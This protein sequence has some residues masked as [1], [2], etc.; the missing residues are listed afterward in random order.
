MPKEGKKA[1]FDDNGETAEDT[2]CRRRRQ[3][4]AFDGDEAVETETGVAADETAAARIKEKK[5]QAKAKR[6]EENDE[7]LVEALPSEDVKKKKKKRASEEAEAEE[8]QALP[9]EKKKKKKRASDEAEAEE[10]QDDA[11]GDK[12]KRKK[13]TSQEVEAVEEQDDAAGDKTKRKKRTSQEVE[14]V[15]E[16][17]E[18]TE[19]KKKRKQRAREEVEAEEEQVEVKDEKKKRNQRAREEGEAAEEQVEVTDE[20]KKRQERPNE[21]VE[22][23]EEAPAQGLRLHVANLAFSVR[24]DALWERFGQCGEVAAVELLLD[25]TGRSR[26][27]AFVT[28]KDGAAVKKAVAMDGDQCDGRPMKVSVAVGQGKRERSGQKA[29]GGKTGSGKGKSGGK[30]QFEVFVGGLPYVIDKD[31]VRKRFEACGDLETFDMP[32][33]RRGSR[34]GTSKGIAWISFQT[35]EGMEKA[36][37]INGTELAGRPLKV[38]RRNREGGNATIAGKQRDEHSENIESNSAEIGNHWSA[39][40]GKSGKDKGKGRGRGDFGGKGKDGKDSRRGQNNREF[41][42]FVGGLPYGIQEAIVRRDFAECGEIARL[43]M[44]TEEDGQTKGIAFINYLSKEAMEKALAFHEQEYGGV[45]IRVL[46]AV[47]PR[48]SESVSRF[49]TDA[50]RPKEHEPISFGEA[51]VKPEGTRQTFDDSDDDGE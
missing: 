10:D 45:W 21:E 49:N 31:E 2:S 35:R 42:V 16:Q 51:A 32:I 20:K 25:Q 4:D 48:N 13:R 8:D 38:E 7:A 27:I 41:E 15:E 1:S 36:L 9:S 5:K 28:F 43:S 26:G 24:E 50:D 18:V 12:T 40:R 3:R 6:E 33:N 29:S 30:R 22:V 23:E 47:A 39:D 44:P 14:A 46:P 34:D 19:V 11:A 17:V 37:E